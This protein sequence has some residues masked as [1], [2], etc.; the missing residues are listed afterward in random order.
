MENLRYKK[1]ICEEKKY[2]PAK[3]L[4]KVNLKNVG[5]T[6]KSQILKFMIKFSLYQR[7]I[8]F[9]V[10]KM[11]KTCNFHKESNNFRFLAIF[12]LKQWF[13]VNRKKIWNI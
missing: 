11:Q 12:S 3:W 10:F 1:N 9:R 5:F 8:T 6:Y 7:K 4:R 2:F 13:F